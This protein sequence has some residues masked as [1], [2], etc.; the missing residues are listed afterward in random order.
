MVLSGSHGYSVVLGDAKVTG[1]IP[2]GITKKTQ[3][4]QT[5]KEVGEFHVCVINVTTQIM[6]QQKSFGLHSV[7]LSDQ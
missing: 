5:E 1:S 3:N 6:A 4:V 7:L 2:A